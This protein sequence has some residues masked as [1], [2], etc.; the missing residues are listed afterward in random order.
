MATSYKLERGEELLDVIL[1]ESSSELRTLALE[2]ATTP[3]LRLAIA[4]ATTNLPMASHDFLR[5]PNR[6]A[7]YN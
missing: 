6:I 5:D 7:I 2:A 3:L 4:C 1:R